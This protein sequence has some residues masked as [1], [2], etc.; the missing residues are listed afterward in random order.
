MANN[1][2]LEMAESVA[3]QYL[4]LDPEISAQLGDLEGRCIAIDVTVPPLKIYC[5]PRAGGLMLKAVCDVEPDCSISGSLMGILKMVRSDNPAE[6]LSSGEVKITGDSRLAQ[7]FSDI[8]S[9][10]DIDWEE[11]LSRLTGDF[12]AHRIGQTVRQGQRWLNE[13]MRALQQDTT[14]YLQEESGI[15]PTRIEIEKFIRDVDVLRDDA[16]RLAVRIRKLE[17]LVTE[18]EL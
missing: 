7:N 17:Y 8:L 13:T 4:S 18:R 1:L 3:N 16:E 14:E 9:R 11:L 2:L 12:V 6:I 5:F 10:M 15:L